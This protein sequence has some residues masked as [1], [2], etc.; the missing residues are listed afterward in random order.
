MSF[1]LVMIFT[2]VGFMILLRY[3]KYKHKAFLLMGI[4]WMG[5]A[6]VW[7]PSGF[8]FVYVLLTGQ[9]FSDEFYFFL[10]NFFS[11]FISVIYVAGITELIYTDKQKAFI[12]IYAIIAVV[13]EIFFLYFLFTD[14][15]VIGYRS[16]VFSTEHENFVLAYL[17]FLNFSVVILGILFARDSLKSDDP[18][19][20]LKGKLLLIAFISLITGGIIDAGIDLGPIVMVFVRI[21]IMSSAFEFYL[22]FILPDWFKKI[23]LKQ[24]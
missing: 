4:S 11:P 6:T 1:I 10:G 20:R 14:L 5:I 21:I 3:F 8:N 22:G 7:Y 18:E 16:G 2:I 12:I 13:F 15:S 19:V 24:E 23:A 9:S 17:I